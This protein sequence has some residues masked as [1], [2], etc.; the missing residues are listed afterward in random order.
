M[1]LS[2]G[3]DVLFEKEQINLGRRGCAEQLQWALFTGAQK[4]DRHREPP[5][6]QRLNSRASGA[7]AATGP[8]SDGPGQVAEPLVGQDAEGR[9][10]GVQSYG[11]RR[12]RRDGVGDWFM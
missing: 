12:G 10:S 6:G 5:H 4:A 7:R 8:T 3:K 1:L 9:I 2:D 11:F